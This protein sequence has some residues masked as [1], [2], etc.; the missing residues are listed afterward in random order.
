MRRAF[1]ERFQADIPVKQELI[2]WNYRKQESEDGDFPAIDI[3][4]LLKTDEDVS[5]WRQRHDV[6]YKAEK[7]KN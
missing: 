1:Y 7:P 4:T 2:S 6:W 5:Q 3:D